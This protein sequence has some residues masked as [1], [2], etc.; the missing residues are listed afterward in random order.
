MK[1]LIIDFEVAEPSRIIDL[2]VSADGIIEMDFRHLDDAMDI[3]NDTLSGNDNE[4]PF[5]DN[6]DDTDTD[7]LIDDLDL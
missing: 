5:D 7:D 4:N 6:S 2:P 1:E 3:E